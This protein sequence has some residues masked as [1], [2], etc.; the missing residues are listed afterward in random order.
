[1]KKK[2]LLVDDNILVARTVKRLLESNTNY[3][4]SVVHGVR[5]A[6]K[7]IGENERFDLAIVDLRLPNGKPQEVVI[8]L[9]AKW[10]A[11]SIIYTSGA[12][13]DDYPELLGKP[14]MLQDIL[15]AVKE[16]IGP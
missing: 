6:E 9:L 12:P 2:I 1:M 3:S 11:I 4:V 13:D 10:P 14:F 16:R 7:V 5:E 8:W 15:N